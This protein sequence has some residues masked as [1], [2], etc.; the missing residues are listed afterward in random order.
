M[1]SSTVANVLP[2]DGIDLRRTELA[3]LIK[4]FAPDFGIHPTAIKNLN[5]IRSDLPTEDLHQIL[6][7]ALCVVIDGRKEV[8]LANETYIYDPLN[9][10]VVSVTL[11]IVG[12][13]IEASPERPYLC[14]R[15]DIDPAQICRLI[16]DA[17]PIGVPVARDGERGLF[18]ERTDI[19]L[20][21][22]V[23]RLLRL[24]E[25]PDDISAL[26]PFAIQEIF[27][28]LLKGQQGQRLHEIAIPD[29]QAHRVNRAIEWLNN[30]YAE[31]LSIDNLAQLINLS[32]SALHHRFKSVTAMSPLQYQKQLRLQEARRLLLSEKSDVSSIGYKMGYES[33]SQFSREYSRLF[34][35]SP[36]K[37]MARLRA[38]AG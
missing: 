5:L 18:L 1:S 25:T 7:P 8:R 34:G 31:P 15:L 10:L 26:A 14:M 19:S 6:K 3:T 38:N 23:L 32:A 36:S 30:H 9:Y 27:Y 20:L 33:L 12:K 21:D 4:K 2:Q 37:D 17:S 24:L 16:A 28:R 13:V 22:A 29:S 11:P 35:A